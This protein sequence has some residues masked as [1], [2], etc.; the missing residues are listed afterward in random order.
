MNYCG[1]KRGYVLPE[2]IPVNYTRVTHTQTHTR[3]E[4]ERERENKNQYFS[5]SIINAI[6]TKQNIVYTNQSLVRLICCM[7]D[8]NNTDMFKRNNNKLLYKNV[9]RTI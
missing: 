9:H 3:R 6:S 4:K 5:D 1:I 7:T 8:F 2:H